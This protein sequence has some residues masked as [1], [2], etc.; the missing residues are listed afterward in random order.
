MI[1]PDNILI[2]TQNPNTT[3]AINNPMEADF[4]IWDLEDDK[5]LKKFYKTVEKEVRGS[6]EYREMIQ[7]LRNNFGMDQCSFIKVN[8]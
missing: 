8:G 1:D 7:Y 4:L 3:V 2:T 6:F 5:E